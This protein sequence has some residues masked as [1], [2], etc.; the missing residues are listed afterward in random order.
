[1]RITEV[2]VEGLFGIFDHT[3]SLNTEE[4]ITII[5]GPNG[6]GK[7]ILLQ[8]LNGL[9]NGN[10]SEFR[11]IPFRKFEVR[12]A[13]GSVIWLENIS[14]S[15]TLQQDLSDSSESVDGTT[16]KQAHLSR[17]P[18]TINFSENSGPPE[19]FSLE[20][21]DEGEVPVS[22]IEDLTGLERIG[23]RQWVSDQGDVLSLDEVIDRF[24]I[25]CPSSLMNQIGGFKL[26]N[27]PRFI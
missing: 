18:I 4:R 6:F 25:V 2:V 8:M 10:Y 3:I 7:T 11:S 17:T 24:G 22:M 20:P 5:H 14:E 23:A 1:M 26:K 21:I 13:E 9:F 27:Q 19:S 12:F 16:R 15:S